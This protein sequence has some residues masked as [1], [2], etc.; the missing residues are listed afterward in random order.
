MSQG[1]DSTLQ[2]TPAPATAPAVGLQPGTMLGRYR[3]E[4]R[5]GSGGMGIV[6]LAHDPQLERKVA[7]K[8]LISTATEASVARLLREAQALARLS[9]PNVVAVHDVG[10]HED[11]VF[12]AMEFV[13][14]D[15][16]TQWL[17][18]SPRNHDEI[19]AVFTSIGH[20]LAAAHS[21]GI[22]HRDFKP[23]NVMVG[24]DG[25][26]RVLDFG[27]A[28]A[29]GLSISSSGEDLRE[30]E[31]A[32]SPRGYLTQPLTI[33]GAI[34]GTPAY[35]APEQFLG[36]EPDV[37]TDQFSFGVALYE[38]LCGRRPF[39]GDSFFE[40]S[41]NVTQGRFL[42]IRVPSVPRWTRAAISRALQPNQADRFGS[43]SEFLDSVARPV[44]WWSKGE[45]R[46]KVW[47]PIAILSVTIP[48]LI[49]IILAFMDRGTTDERLMKNWEKWRVEHGMKPA[50]SAPVAAP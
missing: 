32:G 44:Q 18:K 34:M 24:R 46:R 43:M 36:R 4:S 23:D 30:T 8:L 26:A 21:V 25:R 19:M 6:Y 11:N 27:L 16:L 1:F 42:P 38:A 2:A 41:G 40:L 7:I 13:E 15:T 48:I 45:V 39:A 50:A 9:H 49:V 31:S 20:A 10:I 28:C 37:R 22:V 17:R 12:V 5:L 47:L 35:M 29:V 14:G 3:I 33:T